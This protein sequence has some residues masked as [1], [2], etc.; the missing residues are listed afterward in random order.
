V[1]ERAKAWVTFA[2]VTALLAL[3]FAMA[4]GA[5]AL[6]GDRGPTD[7][8]EGTQTGGFVEIGSN[9]N[10]ALASVNVPAGTYV[11][12]A[13]AWHH[14][15]SVN[16]NPDQAICYAVSADNKVVN[17]RSQFDVPPPN[18]F[19]NAN[20][21][22]FSGTLSVSTPGPVTLRCSAFPLS[23]SDPADDVQA[24]FGDLLLI[25]VGS[26]TTNP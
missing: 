23:V 16:G 17:G 19:T 26:L 25:R 9:A 12:Q 7:A 22:T 10:A 11:V 8:Y 18:Q 6:T 15:V 5:V 20:H 3:V 24:G 21:H 13:G 4:G 2:N 14:T 1:L